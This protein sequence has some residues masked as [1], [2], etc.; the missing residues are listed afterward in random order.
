MGGIEFRTVQKGA[1]VPR[2]ATLPG[3][4]NSLP[5]PASP[6]LPPAAPPPGGLREF[7][8]VWV[9]GALLPVYLVTTF[10]GTLARVSGESME[11]TLHQGDTLLLLK[12]P[13]WLH[14]WGLWPQT[15]RQGDIVI[16]KA[17]AQS[18]YAYETVYGLRRRPYNI[19]RVIAVG[20]D[21]VQVRD[22]VISVNGR[23]LAE[24][25]VSRE[26]YVND[27]GPLQIAP[28]QVWVV[29]DNRR[30][31]SSLDSRSYGP[32][33]LRD[34]AG[35]VGW[36]LWPHPGRLPGTPGA[37]ALNAPGATTPEPAQA[38]VDRAGS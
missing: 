31:G 17:P 36:R 10:G 5:P 33:S 26:G 34:L 24:P 27:E 21:T 37:A 23:P 32:V 12:Y 35:P 4:L 28:G 7:W 11:P 6:A 3:A 14:A 16:F 38:G 22:G 1:L 15:P 2:R 29:G 9:L 25:Y 13:R 30:T 20:G 18:P 8:R 19:K